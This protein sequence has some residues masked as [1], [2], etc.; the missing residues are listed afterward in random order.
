MPKL[1]AM[2][3]HAHEVLEGFNCLGSMAEQ[4][5]EHKHK[6][7]KK[8]RNKF[9]SNQSEGQQIIEDMRQSWVQTSG[10]LM[11]TLKEAELNRIKQGKVIKNLRYS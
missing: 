4:A 6:V 8:N 5:S 3:T 10:I 7:S 2:C 11:K 1:H 9:S